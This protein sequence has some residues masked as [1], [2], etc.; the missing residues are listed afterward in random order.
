[1]VTGR[2]DGGKQVGSHES[3]TC[4]LCPPTLQIPDANF[5]SLVTNDGCQKVVVSSMSS[6]HLEMG[7]YFHQTNSD[8]LISNSSHLFFTNYCLKVILGDITK[9]NSLFCSEL[10]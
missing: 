7:R 5:D 8:P 3:R 1:V 9:H 6:S 10:Y 2:A 4:F